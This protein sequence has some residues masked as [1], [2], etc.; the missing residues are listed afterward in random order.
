MILS[1]KPVE[2][3]VHEL[4]LKYTTHNKAEIQTLALLIPRTLIK[5]RS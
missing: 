3:I 4:P 2:I 1:Q 5:S